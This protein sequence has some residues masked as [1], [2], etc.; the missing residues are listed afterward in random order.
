MGRRERGTRA[1][2]FLH[3]AG[4]HSGDM[5]GFVDEALLERVELYALDLPGFGRSSGRRGHFDSFRSYTVILELFIHLK[6]ELAGVQELFLV[7]EG[8]GALLAF[9]FAN[10]RLSP[11]VKGVVSMPGLFTMKRFFNPLIK[12]S[13]ELLN[14]IAPE[15]YVIERY[16]NGCSAE[17]A[18]Y[19]R[20]VKDRLTVPERTVR[21]VRE[22]DWGLGYLQSNIKTL[23]VPCLIF[24]GKRELHQGMAECLRLL[25]Y[26]DFDAGRHSVIVLDDVDDRASPDNVYSELKKMLLIWLES[27]SFRLDRA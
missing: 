8:M 20:T 23:S 7:G 22:I 5:E 3:C 14:L 15:R 2:L 17:R 18:L 10:E 11:L 21:L 12:G 24:C 19:S 16:L 26:V 13:I 4:G 6:M 1:L 25:S 27:F 9:Y